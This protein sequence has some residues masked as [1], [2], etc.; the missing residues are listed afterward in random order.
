MTGRHDRR[1]RDSGPL[2]S[3]RSPAWPVSTATVSRTLM[4]RRW[5]PRR[6]EQVLRAVADPATPRT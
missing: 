1:P 6:P 4:S 5:W 2:T 3:G